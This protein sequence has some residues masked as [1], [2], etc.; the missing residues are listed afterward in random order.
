MPD[1]GPVQHRSHAVVV[2]G[3]LVRPSG[4]EVLDSKST[5]WI[6]PLCNCLKKFTSVQLPQAHRPTPTPSC[7]LQQADLAP[8]P[9][10]PWKDKIGCLLFTAFTFSEARCV[11]Q[12]SLPSP[13]LSFLAG[14]FCQCRHQ[15][16][17]R[18]TCYW[19]IYTLENQRGPLQYAC[20]HEALF[21]CVPVLP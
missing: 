2:K 7:P 21:S 3:A 16:G 20:I 11:S 13:L 19:Q 6:S 5:S 10:Q 9:W 8:R 18:Q 15:R 14:L 12:E 17:P 1:P 4:R